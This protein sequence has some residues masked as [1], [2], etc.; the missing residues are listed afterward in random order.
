MDAGAR[1]Q[2][3]FAVCLALLGMGLL[4]WLSWQNPPVFHV[5]WNFPVFTAFAVFIVFWGFPAPHIGQ[6]SLERVA[7]VAPIL[8]F[9]VVEAAWINALASLLWPFLDRRIY[10]GFMPALSRG[11]HNVGMFTLMILAGGYLYS[12]LGGQI[13]LR[14][15]GW[16]SGA[17]LVLLAIV[18]Q[19]INELL[20]NVRSW[21]Q[22]KRFT[23]I[24]SIPLT[25]F[26][27]STVLLAV[28]TAL[29]YNLLPLPIFFL[30]VLLLIGLV[31]VLK[32]FANMRSEL[33]TRLEH[34]FAVNRIGR[35]ISAALILD[36]LVEMIY[37]ECRNLFSF[38]AIYL[39]LHDEQENALDFRLHHNEQGR[40]P[41]KRKPMGEGILGWIIDN[42]EPLLIES[43]ATASDSVKRRVVI[44]GETPQSFIGVPV[45]Y[46][47]RVLGAISIQSYTPGTF[48]AQ[49]RDL[50][51]TFAG[52]VA[53][54]ITNARLYTELEQYRHQLEFKV[55]E[56]TREL[57]EQKEAQ[58]RLTESLRATN[59][60]KE[61]LLQKL[62]RQTREDSLTGLANRRYMDE[63]LALELRRAER[64]E[65]SG[66][67]AV[68]DLDFF[69][70]INDTLGHQLGD[71]VLRIVADILRSQCR[72]IDMISR[73]GGEEF[74]LYFPETQEAD[75]RVVC[76]KIRQGVETHNWKELH[77]ELHVT[78]SIGVAGTDHSQPK[79]YS[80]EALFASAD[81]RLYEAKGAG[82]NKVCG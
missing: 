68:A 30:F 67:M 52:Q 82:R 60:E 43:W 69:K 78:I 80:P 75:A 29:F 51:M 16:Q 47:D 9:G 58:R 76:D 17:L 2:F 19:A 6:T 66:T 28:C 79:G 74:L 49:D 48:T 71:D 35:A 15:P 41:R 77:P 45:T 11:L 20:Y 70:Q 53:V 34:M 32:G 64:F 55:S 23:S 65:R 57:N 40:Q 62:E 24:F 36:D 37:R 42:N 25:L 22:H 8:I 73:Y 4:G 54:A 13:P 59:L 3:I 46:G 33:E 12:L 44:V 81:A 61:S 38:T 31:V 1:R 18:M 7:Q 26:E 63:Y 5:W 21:L 14:D 50:L 39:V 72:A 10:R 27:M 56:R